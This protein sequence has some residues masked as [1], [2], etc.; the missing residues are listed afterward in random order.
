[1]VHR[2]CPTDLLAPLA[3]LFVNK[4]LA[5]CKPGFP[6]SLTREE[7]SVGE[8]VNQPCQRLPPGSPELL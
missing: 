8:V 5:I 6:D 3:T 1:M 2:I 4:T 7:G